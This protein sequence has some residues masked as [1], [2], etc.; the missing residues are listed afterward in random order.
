[1]NIIIV[2]HSS[3]TAMRDA[4]STGRLEGERAVVTA[5]AQGIGRAIA[6]RMASEGAQVVAVDIQADRLEA[7]AQ[8]SQHEIQTQ[9]V[10]VTSDSAVS[11]FAANT[12]PP[13]ILVNCVGWV[14]HG[15]IMDCEPADW[16][17]SFALNVESMY[18][19]IR[20]F[21]PSMLAARYG[22]I[23]NIAS[24]VSSVKAAPNRFAYG[25]TKAAVIGL[26]KSVA[27][28][29]IADGIRCNAICPGTVE[30]PSLEE[31]IDAFDDPVAARRDF[32]ARQP[33]GRLGT[34]EEIAAVALH[35]AS[36]ESA[37]TTGHAH[38]IDGGMSL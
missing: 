28:D 36:R 14:H 2:S 24:V 22:S 35:F 23:V 6:L 11:G 25:T 33:M 18:R 30:S 38:V 3:Q 12:A 17:R 16:Q 19:T 5:A 13:T 37:Y 27:T 7:M 31:R 10:D 34:P 32:I 29:F 26:T 15:T 4:L 1:M 9:L 8:E 21:L 20:A